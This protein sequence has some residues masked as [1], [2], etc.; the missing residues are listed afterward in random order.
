MVFRSIFCIHV[1]FI[2]KFPPSIANTKQHGAGSTGS[3]SGRNLM[4]TYQNRM[5]TRNGGDMHENKANNLGTFLMPSEHR[6][7]FKLTGHHKST[8]VYK[9][10]CYEAKQRSYLCFCLFIYCFL[11]D[12]CN[13]TFQQGNNF[14]YGKRNID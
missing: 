9:F 12:F 10:R 1:V 2:L 11:F 14:A 5:F 13:H 7:L 6:A 3:S 4:S 8:K